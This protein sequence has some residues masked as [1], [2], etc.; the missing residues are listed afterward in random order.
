MDERAS[1]EA[2]AVGRFS[3]AVKL[4]AFE[5]PLDLLLHLIQKHELDIFDIPVSFVTER[6]LEYLRVMQHLNLDVA[7]EYLLMAATLAHIKSRAV[8]RHPTPTSWPTSWARIRARK[9]RAP[10]R[11]VRAVQRSGRR[12]GTCCPHRAAT[13]SRGASD[14]SRAAPSARA[15]WW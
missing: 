3:C 5:G 10:A 13:C 14:R 15:C 6:Y 11:R 7:A 9:L 2:T 8:A 1:R 12:A 4:P